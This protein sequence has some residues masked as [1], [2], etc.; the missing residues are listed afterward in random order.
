M[1]GWKEGSEG[2]KESRRKEAGR[3][4]G[5]ERKEGIRPLDFRKVKEHRKLVDKPLQKLSLAAYN[6]HVYQPVNYDCSLV[7]MITFENN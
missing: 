1:K 7:L 3:G 6:L 4:K 5:G 2:G